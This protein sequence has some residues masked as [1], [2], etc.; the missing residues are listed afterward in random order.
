MDVASLTSSAGI[1]LSKYDY[2][3]NSTSAI[4]FTTNYVY[5]LPDRFMSGDVAAVLLTLVVSYILL[6][7]INK[8]TFA[9]LKVMKAA[10]LVTAMGYAFYNFGLEMLF[11]VGAVGWTAS[12]IA[13]GIGG[14]FAGVIASYFA[15]HTL[16]FSAKSA[17]APAR[18]TEEKK[19]KEK[20]EVMS[21]D[22]LSKDKTLASVLTY[23]VIA[24]FGVFSSKTIAAPKVE[25]GL[26]F[27]GLFLFA[28]LM[29][30]K[31]SYANYLRGLQHLLVA[32]IVGGGISILLGYAWGDYSLATLLS[33]EYFKTD[34][35]VALVTGLA[36]SLFMSNK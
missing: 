30:V 26:V 10:I 14:T 22:A 13:L 6:V 29:F 33:L 31:Q 4:D 9:L 24:E 20:G 16:Y 21:L 12:N 2:L 18:P 27:F 5:S 32:L 19:A 23:L 11:R 1:D 7:L 35:L 17:K 36:V 3:T 25:T 15:I 28:A 34:C 8:L